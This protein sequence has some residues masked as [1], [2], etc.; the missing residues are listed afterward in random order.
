MKRPERI[1]VLGQTYR[2]RV[3]TERAEGFEQ[4]DY[5]ECDAD[6]H[7]ISIIAGRSHGNDQNTLT[8]EIFHAIAFELDLDGA[9]NKPADNERW[10]QGLATGWLAVLKDNAG[11][12]SY[13]RSK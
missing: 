5:G 10:I 11:L 9:I 12:V 4:G 7:L 8:H 2:V 13:L 6:K 3:I 1:K